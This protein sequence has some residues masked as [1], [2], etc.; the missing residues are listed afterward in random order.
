MSHLYGIIQ[1][2]PHDMAGEIRQNEGES[3]QGPQK[4]HIWW[5]LSTASPVTWA[6][7]APVCSTEKPSSL[8]VTGPDCAEPKLTA[9]PLAEPWE[10][11]KR[12][13]HKKINLNKGDKRYLNVVEQQKLANEDT[14]NINWWVEKP[15]SQ[16]KKTVRCDLTFLVIRVRIID[17]VASQSTNISAKN[18]NGYLIRTGIVN[19]R[20]HERQ[21]LMLYR[22][23]CLYWQTDY[24]T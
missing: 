10:K 11:I 1:M 6:L 5:T 22:K 23:K 21:A 7:T 18:A 15:I 3:S 2:K 9:L 16:L 12:V 13:L 8:F 19:M 4:N 20:S 14:C 24:S 17:I